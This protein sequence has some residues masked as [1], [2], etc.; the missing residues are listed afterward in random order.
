MK[1]CII[2]ALMFVIS[3]SAETFT[4]DWSSG[5]LNITS[6]TTFTYTQ[7]DGFGGTINVEGT[8]STFDFNTFSGDV[9]LRHGSN[10]AGPLNVNISHSS[11]AL[12]E[13][14]SIDVR[15]SFSAS[16]FGNP[17]RAIVQALDAGGSFIASEDFETNLPFYQTFSP[18]GDLSGLSANQFRVRIDHNSNGRRPAIDN[19]VFSVSP[20]PEPS[21]YGFFLLGVVIFCFRKKPTNRN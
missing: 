16:P 3:V 19:L 17:G 18:T 6:A 4:I 1:R 11:G 2:I 9:E 12:I 7:S 10:F 21:T 14:V 8:S 5:T 20:I 13:L 15:D